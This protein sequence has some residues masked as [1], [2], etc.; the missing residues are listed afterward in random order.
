MGNASLSHSA[1]VKYRLCRTEIR[2]LPRLSSFLPEKK[3]Q[4]QL[5]VTT[6]AH[7]LFSKIEVY[8]LVRDRGLAVWSE[9][10]NV[11][12]QVSGL[13]PSVQSWQKHFDPGVEN[14]AFPA[15]VPFRL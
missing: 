13:A 12:R 4:A 1:Q 8:S 15:Q 3:D 7:L 11:A 9:S 6:P 2:S 10:R 5:H 14:R